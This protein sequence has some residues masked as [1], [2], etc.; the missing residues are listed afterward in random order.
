MPRLNA[1]ISAS[2]PGGSLTETP[3][4]VGSPPKTIVRKVFIST[5]CENAVEEFA[6]TETAVNGAFVPSLLFHLS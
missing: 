2:A 3:L 4:A 5:H 6:G 1:S